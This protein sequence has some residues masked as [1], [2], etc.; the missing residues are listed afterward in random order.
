M[1]GR[2]KVVGEREGG[3]FSSRLLGIDGHLQVIHVEV[4]GVSYLT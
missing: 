3:H 4:V 1:R 2:Q